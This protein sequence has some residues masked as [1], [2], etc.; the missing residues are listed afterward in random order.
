LKQ[1]WDDDFDPRLEG[2]DDYL[3]DVDDPHPADRGAPPIGEADPR[4]RLPELGEWDAGD[5]AKPPP[6]RGWLLGTV[7]CRT[8]ISSLIAEGGSGKTTLRYAQYLSLATGRPLTGEHVFQ[9]CR[10]LVVSLEDSADELKR[11]ILAAR[12]HH[13]V[14]LEE[15]RGWLFLSAPG[16]HAGK[17]LTL[18]Q[19]GRAE[20]G[21][22]GKALEDVI[23]RRKIDL[24]ALDL[25]IKTRAVTE[26]DNNL[27]DQVAQILVDLAAKHALS[28]DVP[29]HVRKSTPEP[30][31]ADR[32]RGASAARDAARLVY[33]LT[34]M[35]PAEAQG[36]S[37][38][39]GERRLFFRVDS[40]KVNIAPPSLK[41]KWFKLIGVK[42]GNATELY[43]HG[44]EAQTVEPWT[45]P[46]AFEDLDTAT[47]N[48]ILDTIE[49]GLADGEKYSDEGAA[50]ARAAWKAVKI[51][52][53]DKTEAQCKEVIR[54]W[55][56]NGLLVRETYHRD[57]R[58]EDL[59]GLR[60]N[61]GK[62]PGTKTEW[63]E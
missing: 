5:D 1:P 39:E 60:V 13:N 34:T 28:V 45:P 37:I 20:I 9:R 47:C 48:R 23:T 63:E 58:R 14:S 59:T 19:K 29:H 30:G 35:T 62:R 32:G 15:V 17:P 7:F 43:P 50:R 11:R 51:H 41:A 26:N 55:V 61:N 8:F 21:T 53:K 4:P 38:P 27:I 54:Q 16:A 10:V 40:A 18:N 42:L 33:S 44:D 24:I 22:L 25:F 12:L 36:F 2:F 57:K 49:A 31:N 56:K 46:P 3:E 6:P 52:A